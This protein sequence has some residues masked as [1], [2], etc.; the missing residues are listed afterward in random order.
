LQEMW[1]VYSRIQRTSQNR[2]RKKTD[3]GGV[4]SEEVSARN[5]IYQAILERY[6][7]E[8][9][10][11]KNLDDKA[12]SIIGVVG[13]A[14]SFVTGLGGFLL[15]DPQYRIIMSETRT[16]LPVAFFFINIACFLASLTFGLIAYHI[17]EYT[18][19]PAPFILIAKYGDKNKTEVT[20]VLQS[21]YADAVEK[22]M[23]LNNKKVTAVK[24]SFY[25]LYLSLIVLFIFSLS[26]IHT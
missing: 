18:H 25:L 6:R 1:K 3:K 10:R 12:S 7:E 13:I 16:I 23:I 14:G 22:N 24:R 8:W 4:L 26:L 20:A 19:V 15:S 21:T 11:T 2:E 9:E 17:R 5:L